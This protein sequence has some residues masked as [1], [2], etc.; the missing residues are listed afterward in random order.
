MKFSIKLSIEKRPVYVLV[1]IAYSI[2]NNNDL[3]DI[4]DFAAQQSKTF[5]KKKQIR[6]EEKVGTQGFHNGPEELSDPLTEKK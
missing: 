6:F 2:K 1:K 3:K 5:T 4:E